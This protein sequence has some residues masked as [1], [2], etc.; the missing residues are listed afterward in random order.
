MELPID[1]MATP[2]LAQ[3]LVPGTEHCQRRC[4][5]MCRQPCQL[6]MDEQAP[7]SKPLCANLTTEL[8]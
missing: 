3:L 6:E 1:T 5:H 2:V 8:G 7:Q 4:S